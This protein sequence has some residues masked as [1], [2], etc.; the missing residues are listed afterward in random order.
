MRR[1]KL[2]TI[3]KGNRYLLFNSMTDDLVKSE[4]ADEAEA[5][6]DYDSKSDTSSRPK[7][8]KLHT[9][10]KWNKPAFAKGVDR[11]NKLFGTSISVKL[12]E[13]FDITNYSEMLGGGVN[14]GNA[15]YNL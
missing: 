11:V 13:K 7:K 12:N 15:E 1:D 8:D 9:V 3:N 6:L 2:Y 14:V 10:T 4:A 5:P